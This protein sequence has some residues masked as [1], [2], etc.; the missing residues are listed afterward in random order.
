MLE[1]E[2]MDTPEDARNYNEMDHSEV[3]RVFVD[4][5]LACGNIAGDILDLGTGTALIPIELCDRVDN[6]RV[7]ASDMSTSMLDLA[8]YNL[9]VS[10][11]EGR[12]QLD[13]A[14]A[15]QLHYGDDTFDI[16]MSNSIVHHIPEPV[17]VLREAVRVT[18]P[19]GL[20]FFRDLMRPENSDVVKDLVATYAAGANERQKKMFDDSLRAALTLEEIRSLVTSLGFPGATVQATSDRHWTWQARIPQVESAASN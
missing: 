19:G 17:A 2:V 18:R 4:D 10:S 14:D 15:K 5:L 3:N 9:A 20:L 8:V 11:A 6:C 7:M 1:P 16:V 12:I 13:R